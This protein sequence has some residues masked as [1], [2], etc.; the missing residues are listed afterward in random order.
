MTPYV[1]I[2]Q[3]SSA[4]L[5]FPPPCG[6]PAFY[7]R[8]KIPA[9]S[10]ARSADVVLVTGR[11]GYPMQAIRCGSCGAALKPKTA[12]IRP[13]TLRERLMMAWRMFLRRLG[14]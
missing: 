4:P 14:L 5:G 2:H 7:L 1:M 11:R 12:E 8:R 10:L 6:K 3:G 9:M 13:T